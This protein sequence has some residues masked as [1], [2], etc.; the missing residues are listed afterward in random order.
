MADS[1]PIGQG[2]SV[3]LT[4][5]D[6]PEPAG[7]LDVIVQVLGDNQIVGG[8]YVIGT[9][10]KNNPGKA[11]LIVR[12]G[13]KIQNHSWSHINLQTASEVKVR[14]EVQQTQQI[15]VQATGVRPTKLRPPY[16]NGGWPSKLD[17]EIVHV[18]HEFSLKIE[19]WD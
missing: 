13:H 14:Q 1:K 4:F 11:R 18:A 5:D 7:A 17:P 9:E 10:V 15:V 19:N 16:G 12:R 3:L 2:R 6:G 8:F